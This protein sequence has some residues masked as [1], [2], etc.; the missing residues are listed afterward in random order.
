[1]ETESLHNL[2]DN[3]PKVTKKDTFVSFLE[4]R[5]TKISIVLAIIGILVTIVSFVY[6]RPEKWD[7]TFRKNQ[8]NGENQSVVLELPPVKSF[9]EHLKSIENRETIKMWN[10]CSFYRR[11]DDLIN[12]DNMLYD[13][14]LTK[15][16][17]VLYII[18]LVEGSQKNA[19]SSSNAH[20]FTFYALLEFEDDVRL[21]GEVD[22]LKNFDKTT[23]LEQ[24]RDSA[25]FES[26]FEP[27][28][29]EVYE[30]VDHRFVIDSAEYI[31]NRLREYMMEE[32]T[33]KAYVTQDWRFPV[34]F[35]KKY[36][37]PRKTIESLAPY[38]RQKHLM[39]S[40]V[41][42]IEEDGEW[43]VNKFETAALS[44]WK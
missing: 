15:K 25:F 24:I 37:L 31:R 20:T 8:V 16:Y 33:L 29:Q 18:P 3:K 35:A 34:L 40:E 22:K 26:L 9:L 6:E 4:K 14:Y 17:N 5:E 12:N 44:R 7:K 30:F 23:S 39:L 11:R 28:L 2:G 21:E 27:V 36:K 10:Q 43:K 1:M 38:E 41:V 13:Y 42:M 19:K 32:M